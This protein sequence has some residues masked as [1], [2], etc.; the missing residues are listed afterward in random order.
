M[1][2]FPVMGKPDVNLLEQFF[3]PTCLV[4]VEKKA[5]RIALSQKARNHRVEVKV[6]RQ[7]KQKR[8]DK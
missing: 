7:K 8:G 1:P 5:E 6:I 4:T 2:T 3:E